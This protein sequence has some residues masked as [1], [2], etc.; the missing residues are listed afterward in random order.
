MRNWIW[1]GAAMAFLMAV[2]MFLGAQHAAR[3]PNS[4]VGRCARTVFNI[5]DATIPNDITADFVVADVT[6]QKPVPQP[7]VRPE[8]I[9]PIVVSATEEEPPLASPRLSPEIV[10]AIE[11]LRGEEESEAPP[12]N[13]D[14]P[15]QTLRMPYADEGP[16]TLPA[17]KNEPRILDREDDGPSGAG[18]LFM[19]TSYWRS[20][21]DQVI[22][23]VNKVMTDLSRE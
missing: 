21:V 19:P 4:L 9:E 15:T 5:A 17:P 13:F 10:A 22:D 8:V 2:G 18:F 3:Y 1:S 11:R 7:F 16:E 20:L 12:R 23:N 14:N 6:N